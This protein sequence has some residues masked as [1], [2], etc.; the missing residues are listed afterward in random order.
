[1]SGQPRGRVLIAL[2]D[3]HPLD[4]IVNQ[5]NVF[6]AVDGMQPNGLPEELNQNHIRQRTGSQASRNG[7]MEPAANA[8]L[9]PLALE[10]VERDGREAPVRAPAAAALADKQVPVQN[11]N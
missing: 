9:L 10:L 6:R 1:P 5:R 11:A 4:V 8:A 2:V 7:Q 3:Q